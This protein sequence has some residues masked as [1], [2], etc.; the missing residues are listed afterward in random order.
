MA[1][2]LVK[3]KHDVNSYDLNKDIATIPKEM[4][5]GLDLNQ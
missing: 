4:Y 2:N 1:L 5:P 3:A